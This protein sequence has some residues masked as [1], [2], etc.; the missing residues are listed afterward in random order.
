[1]HSHYCP[2]CRM[3]L[4]MMKLEPQLV[5][6][7]ITKNQNTLKLGLEAIAQVGSFKQLMVVEPPDNSRTWR[8]AFW[9]SIAS[10]G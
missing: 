4:V 8:Q 6:N 7:I 1:M 3:P 2:T 5:G 10:K 9:P